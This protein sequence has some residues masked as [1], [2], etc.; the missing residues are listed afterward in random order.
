MRHESGKVAVGTALS[1]P[2]RHVVKTIVVAGADWCWVVHA[3]HPCFFRTFGVIDDIAG[4][5]SMLRGRRI[6]SWNVCIQIT[7]H[8]SGGKMIPVVHVPS[9]TAFDYMAWCLDAGAGGI[10][11]PHLETVEEMKAV[12]ILSATG[13]SRL[14]LICAAPRIS[15]PRA[16]ASSPSL[17]S[18]SPSS[19]KSNLASGSR[20]SRPIMQ[21]D[22]ISAFMIGSRMGDLRLDMGLS[23]GL[24]GLEPEFVAAIQKA[25]KVSKARNIPILGAAMGREMV[26]QRIDQGYR[27]IVCCMDLHTLAYET[28]QTLGEARAAAEEHMK[29]IHASGSV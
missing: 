10:I 27:A 12:I 24:D 1:Y 6:S 20:T 16:K 8:E 11:F 15:P 2:S 7:I 17:T 29:S 19:R 26:K 3:T 14:S 9:K 21:M 28:I 5:Q 23:L 4:T 25:T 22:E 13:R 18:T